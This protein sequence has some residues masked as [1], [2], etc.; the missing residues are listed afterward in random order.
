MQTGRVLVCV[1]LR[2]GRY[3]FWNQ[4]LARVTG[5]PGLI[6]VGPEGM[7]AREKRQYG[8]LVILG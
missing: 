1:N 5:V 3:L 7:M 4:I 8:Q 6:V 2:T